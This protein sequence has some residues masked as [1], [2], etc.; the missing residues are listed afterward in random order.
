[1]QNFDEIISALTISQKIR[2]LTHAGDLSGK[3]MKILGIPKIETGDMKDYGRGLFPNATALINCWNEDIW[4]KVAEA[5]ADMLD[6][7]GKNF[8]IAP[9]PK[10]KISPYRREISEDVC[11]AAR[12]SSLHQKAAAEKGLTVA[13][14]G[15]Y[16]T[17]SDVDWL[18]STPNDRT[19]HEFITAPY[20]DAMPNAHA[21]A[22]ITD[23]RQTTKSYK[24]VPRALEDEIEQYADFLIC[25]LA[26]EENTVDFIS[27]GII[28]LEGSELALESAV[29]RY[30]KLSMS[31]ENNEG[32]TSEQLDDEVSRCAA[33]APETLDAA[34][35]RLF[36]FI[37]TVNDGEE[38]ERAEIGD[39]SD[40]ALRATVESSV[41]LKNNGD[42]LPLNR[43]RRV[44]IIGDIAFR[45]V[46]GELLVN[47][48]MAELSL[49]GY[50]VVG[51][52]RGYDMEA[53]HS[54]KLTREALDLASRC[55]TVIMLLGFGYEAEKL[56]PKT[57]TLSLPA[58]QISLSKKI[59]YNSGRY[60]QR[61]TVALI[62]AGHAPDVAFSAD[63]DSVMLIPL[64]VSSSAK[65]AAMLLSGEESPSGKLAY[66]LYSDSDTAFKKAKRYKDQYS[67]KTGPFIG[68][69]YY[70]TAELTVGYPFGHGL[71]YAKLR[72][73]GLSVS[74]GKVTFT[75]EN[76]SDIDAHEVVEIY[77]GL[78]NPA[79]INPKKELCAFTKIDISGGEKKTFTLPFELPKK[80]IGNSFVIPGGSYAIYV[81]SSV[82]D[83][84]L[85][86]FITHSGPAVVSDGERPCD[87]LQSVSNVREDNYT[88]EANY[89]VMKKSIRN[90]LFGAIFIA[91]AL[92]AGIFNGI[93]KHPSIFVGVLAAALAA[94]A[95]AFFISEAIVRS[96][97]Y[98]EERQ[99]INEINAQNFTAAEPLPDL[100]PAKMFSEEFETH[101]PEK[102]SADQVV[103]DTAETI[104][105]EYIDTEFTFNSA[106]AEFK[107]FLESRGVRLGDC[108]AENLLSSIATSGLIITCGMDPEEFAGLVRVVCEYFGTE[109]F[110]DKAEKKSRFDNSFFSFDYHGDFFKKN[111]LL[112]LDYARENPSKI[113]IAAYDGATTAVLKEYLTPFTKYLYSP[114]S[115]NRIFIGG[116]LGVDMSYN[117]PANLRLFVNLSDK[118]SLDILPSHFASL[119]AVNAISFELCAPDE[120]FVAPHEL[121]RYQLDFMRDKECAK[122]D[123]S[124]EVWKKIDKLEKY[125][126]RFS[127][128]SIGNKLWLSFEKHIALLL[129]SGLVVSEA[130]DAAIAARLVASISVALKD[131]IPDGE[132][133]LAESLE[134]IFG[135]GNADLSIKVAE[136]MVFEA[137]EPEI[138]FVE[139]TEEEAPAPEQSAAPAY[140]APAYETPAYETPA[141]EAPIAPAEE[142]PTE[143]APTEEAPAE[144]APAEEAPVEEATAEGAPIEENAT[145]EAP[146][147][148]S[149]FEEP[150]D[151][152]SQE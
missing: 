67:M 23:L 148:E 29:A 7:D 38:R 46:G 66:T 146:V 83:V 145:E 112:A 21:K 100:A 97:I 124:E 151:N 39:F 85:K 140:E 62:S 44:G 40:L 59:L 133:L 26:T 134:F 63:F 45:E 93:T 98:A 127:D 142:V 16:I 81:S 48:L 120:D 141:Y 73:S 136:N 11:L 36:E 3:D 106:V 150:N 108:V 114:K 43:G 118:T 149:A 128:Y 54:D 103:E 6:S 92:S 105:T 89:S 111:I 24:R 86:T 104:F 14:S 2:M 87:Y 143:E 135:E 65:A 109:I 80:Y 50:R 125:A 131:N 30:K 8:V 82:S 96:R 99:R 18:D 10:L 74:D 110:L 33:I 90:I 28:C 119:G 69:R 78:E 42:I 12:F 123:I 117:V 152:N 107:K 55:D 137:E 116:E 132:Q 101:E 64:E 20:I 68:Y 138:V 53:T 77:A 129:S 27:R 113:A 115:T 61:K 72:Y 88:L 144:E 32:A 121:N 41:L 13:P 139:Q 147:E 84:R 56:I 51:A 5:K 15:F 60:G 49:R 4:Y 76:R 130:V 52:A 94:V 22:I 70:D 126:K 47:R 75:V 1:M 71:S 95:L 58:N 19:I 35:I 122:A 9:G 57:E 17:K 34:L 102:E 79:F 91:L 25:R 31:I 37:Y